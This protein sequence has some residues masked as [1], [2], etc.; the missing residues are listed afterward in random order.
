MPL[1]TLPFAPG[2][3]TP[4]SYPPSP[5]KVRG[6]REARPARAGRL[7]GL[8]LP[9]NVGFGWDS[10]WRSE[11][12]FAR[13]EPGIPL[14]PGAGVRGLRG[15]QEGAAKLRVGG[16]QHEGSVQAKKKRYVGGQEVG[17]SW[18]SRQGVFWS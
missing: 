1:A 17:R 7:L 14:A 3:A 15:E 12:A 6:G 10:G 9:A 13:F 18:W 16:E 5:Q 2:Y 11:A 8:H 4:L